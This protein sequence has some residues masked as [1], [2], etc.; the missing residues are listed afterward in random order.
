M[1]RQPKLDPTAG[2]VG[3]NWRHARSA[4]D[5]FTKKN[6]AD[7]VIDYVEADFTNVKFAEFNVKLNASFDFDRS[8]GHTEYVDRIF[9][10][11]SD[12][13]SFQILIA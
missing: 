3:H 12:W 13:S 10:I 9:I 1:T 5:F 2:I 6:V 11:G 8:S 4:F 7:H